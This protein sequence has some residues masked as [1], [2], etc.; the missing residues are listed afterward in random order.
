MVL[1]SYNYARAT[2]HAR[3]LLARNGLCN[4]T[5][6]RTSPQEQTPSRPTQGSP[7]EKNSASPEPGIGY[8]LP[9]ESHEGPLL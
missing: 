7:Q 2:M 1:R 8:L 6:E 9:R 3:R 4:M 5:E